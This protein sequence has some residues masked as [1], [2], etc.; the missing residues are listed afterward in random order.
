MNQPIVVIKVGGS[1]LDW[2]DLPARLS[3][4]LADQQANRLVLIVGG[5]GFADLLRDHDQRHALGEVRAHALAMR[6]LDLTAWVLQ[7]L[8]PGLTV[9]EDRHALNEVWARGHT[10]I[11]A[12]RRFLEH[13][14][15]L[16]PAWT[17][18]T[19]SIA[20]RVATHLDASELVLLKSAPWPEG[21][22]ME[23]AVI[24]GL[25]DPEFPRAVAK[26]ATWTYHD[27]R[28]QSSFCR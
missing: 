28:G 26:V 9:V 19:D 20:A 22:G 8:L 17:T 18:T 2:P 10:P 23:Q 12:P 3:A 14:E 13:D 1:L 7:D 6:V 25:L 27:L 11:L 24:M 5:G 16:P 15:Q 4:Y 21:M